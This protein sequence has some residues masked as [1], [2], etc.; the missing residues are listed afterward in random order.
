MKNWVEVNRLLGAVL[1]VQSDSSRKEGP[2]ILLLHTIR[3]YQSVA[4]GAAQCC[5]SDL[6]GVGLLH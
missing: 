2:V 4:E 1:I 3:V 6:Q 5:E